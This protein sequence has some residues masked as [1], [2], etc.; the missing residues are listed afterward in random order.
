MHKD[1]ILVVDDDENIVY[2][3]NDAL[4]RE[5]FEVYTATNGFA[6][7]QSLSMKHPDLIIVDV[8]MPAMDGFSMLECIRRIGN[9]IP[10]L[11]LTARSDIEDVLH[12]FD[13]G[14]NDYIRKPFQLSELVARV[15]AHLRR[16]K[17]NSTKDMITIG[18]CSLDVPMHKITIGKKSYNLTYIE[19]IV[20]CELMS[21]HDFILETRHLIA[22]VW[23]AYEFS[24]VNR[25]HGYIHKIRQIIE[26]SSSIDIVNVRGVG[27]KLIT[28]PDK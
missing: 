12:G 1:K 2:I 26:E 18:D 5:G 8:M 6:G 27:Y 23:G 21:H 24:N 3:I 7:M 14:A 16:R 19:T 10:V 17:S 20:L 22:V 13:L 25:L 11:M 9:N 28:K 4:Q 15:R